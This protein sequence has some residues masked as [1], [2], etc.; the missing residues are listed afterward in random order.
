LNRF[1]QVLASF[2]ERLALRVSTRQFGKIA[3]ETALF[4]FFEDRA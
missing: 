1:D 4:G 3:D 2:F